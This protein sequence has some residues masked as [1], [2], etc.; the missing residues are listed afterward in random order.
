M[1]LNLAALPK[2]DAWEI[3][4]VA[5]S[6]GSMIELAACA[7]RRGETPPPYEYLLMAARNA[8][9][10][11]AVDMGAENPMRIMFE[12]YYSQDLAP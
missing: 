10:A 1:K 8:S 4:K 7:A 2:S 3:W 5:C 9:T 6:S 11:A 12:L